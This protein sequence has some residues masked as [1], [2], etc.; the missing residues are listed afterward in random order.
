MIGGFVEQN[1]TLRLDR[2][3]YNR[4]LV[5]AYSA[6]YVHALDLRSA[7]YV[8]LAHDDDMR[9]NRVFETFDKLIIDAIV[10]VAKPR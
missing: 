1:Q 3:G 8:L 4:L 6:L 5:F 7:K 9:P 2:D 10:R